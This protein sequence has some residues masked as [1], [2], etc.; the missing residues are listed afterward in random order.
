MLKHKPSQGALEEVEAQLKGL[1]RTLE[2][3]QLEK[4]SREVKELASLQSHVER[5]HRELKEKKVNQMARLPPLP[6]SQPR[7]EPKRDVN[8]FRRPVKSALAEVRRLKQLGNPQSAAGSEWLRERYN[9]PEPTKVHVRNVGKTTYSR[10]KIVRLAQPSILPKQYRDN[11]LADPPPIT[12]KDI[13]RGLLDLISKGFIPKDVDLTPAFERGVPAYSVRA[14]DYIGWRE[15]APLPIEYALPAPEDKAEIQL[16][17]PSMTGESRSPASEM[18]I[19]PV[20]E[21]PEPIRTYEEMVDAFS[22]HQLMLRKGKVITGTPEFSSFWRIYAQH[23]AEITDALQ[24]A[25][26]IFG[27]YS[28]P[29]V[30]L[31]GKRLAELFTNEVRKISEEDL[32]SCVINRDQ[33]LPFTS[34]RLQLSGING[35]H[36][37]A[38]KIQTAYRRYRAASAYVQLKMLKFKAVVIQHAFKA[39]KNRKNTAELIQSRREEQLAAFT[40]QQAEFMAAWGSMYTE[41]RIEVHIN[42]QGKPLTGD[43]TLQDMQIARLFRLKDPQ[44]NIIYVTTTEMSKDLQDHY[45]RLL[46]SNGFPNCRERVVILHAVFFI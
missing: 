26:E 30:F 7:P 13:Q 27:K 28:I 29:L 12:E 4:P 10:P 19:V 37:A 24:F 15:A 21:S 14:A 23:W 46:E 35:R 8:E 17:E 25:E 20:A 38:T 45:F 1:K 31:N 39:Y 18:Q 40:Q 16:S 33:V 44:V 5:V 22:S 6:Q 9:L 2:L 41:P 11:P 43:S 36:H 32:F 3:M 34:F 42:S